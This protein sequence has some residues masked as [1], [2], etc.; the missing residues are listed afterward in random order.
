MLHSS[1]GGSRRDRRPLYAVLAFAV[2]AICLIAAWP[3]LFPSVAATPPSVRVVGEDRA[4]GTVF[5]PGVVLAGGSNSTASL[6]GGIGVYHRSTDFSLPVLADVASGP[7]GLTVVNRSA[8]F[9][10][11]FSE[12]GVY[13]IAWNGTGW[14]IG[15]Q[16]SQGVKN[17][18]ALVSLYHGRITNLSGAV[19]S[20]FRGGGI[21]AVAWNGT[22]W[23]VGGN[24]S[25]GPALVSWS[26]NGARNLSSLPV[27]HG[28]DG[29]VQLLVWNGFEWLVGGEK[30]FGTLEGGQ[31]RDLDPASPFL[32]SGEFA[33]AWTGSSWVVGGYGARL[34]WVRSGTVEA[35]P[36]L[37]AGFD[38][39]VTFVIPWGTGWLV[40]GRGTAPNGA[41][42]PELL[43]WNGGESAGAY[44]DLSARLP[45][46]FLQGEIQGAVP[47][48]EIAAGAYLLVGEGAYDPG[49]GYGVGAVALLTP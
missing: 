46:S 38:R 36:A 42:A 1:A 14:L 22:G 5:H 6:L 35:A 20:A 26:A 32:S 21:W 28:S 17:E 16:R 25:A 19:A 44:V 47:S 2:A 39:F 18:G 7:Q 31:Y 10:R 9:A 24:S 40:G 23:L 45:S 34:V 12:G 11:F 37:P 33:A 43:Y 49:T 4:L 13:A 15:G 29:W 8:D 3:N 48:P 27:S 30:V 41:Y